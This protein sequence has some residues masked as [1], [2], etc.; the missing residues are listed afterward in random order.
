MD[1]VSSL[2]LLLSCVQRELELNLDNFV[3]EVFYGAIYY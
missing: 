3:S 2:I 1:L